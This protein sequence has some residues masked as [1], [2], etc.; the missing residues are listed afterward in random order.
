MTIDY[1]TISQ[2]ERYIALARAIIGRE[3]EIFSYSINIANYTTMLE[4]LPKDEW[5]NS[6][7]KYKGVDVATIVDADEDTLNAINDYGYRD[8]IAQLLKTENIELNKSKRVYA[9]LC[10]QIPEDKFDAYIAQ[11]KNVV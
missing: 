5:P 11:A 9:A 1:K 6:I 8:R 10:A 3:S 2:D 4:T 7:A